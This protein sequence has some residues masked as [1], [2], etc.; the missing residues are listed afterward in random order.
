M[1]E[2]SR[3]KKKTIT[4][5]RMIHFAP[6]DDQVGAFPLTRLDVPG[7]FFQMLPGNQRTHIRIGLIAW[8]DFNGR[9][10]R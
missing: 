9:N 4:P 8:P 5:T 10:F 7:N 3:A 1:I 2:E 6:V